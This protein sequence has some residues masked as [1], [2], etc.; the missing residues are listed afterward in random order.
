MH[1]TSLLKSSTNEL[2]VSV[3]SDPQMGNGA[4]DRQVLEAAVEQ[5]AEVGHV[6]EYAG[7]L[8]AA[9][10]LDVQQISAAH[11]AEPERGARIGSRAG[12]LH[13]AELDIA[14]VTQIEMLCSSQ[15]PLRGKPA[16]PR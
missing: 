3:C 14:R 15:S 12:D 2:S 6:I 4:V 13:I 9:G 11:I 1:M 5:H 10:K 7:R 8:G 16:L